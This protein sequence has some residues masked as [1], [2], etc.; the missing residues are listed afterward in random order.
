MSFF[1]EKYISFANAPVDRNLSEIYFGCYYLH[2]CYYIA[3]I[4]RVFPQIIFAEA[5]KTLLEVLPEGPANWFCYRELSV[6]SKSKYFQI[7]NFI[8]YLSI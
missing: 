4:D 6:L 1:G 3:C 5:Y 7:S 2:Y 8:I